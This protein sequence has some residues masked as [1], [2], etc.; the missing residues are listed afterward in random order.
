MG[1]QAQARP[2]DWIE[3]HGHT[4]GDPPRL[5]LV[6]EVLGEAGQEHYRVRWDEEHESILYPGP[7]AVIRP[8]KESA[9]KKGK[10]GGGSS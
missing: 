8:A 9:G 10:K 5:A 3:I 2:G 1:K 6:L 4:Q 7:D